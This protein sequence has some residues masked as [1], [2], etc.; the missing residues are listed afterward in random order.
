MPELPEVE[1]VRRTLEPA[2]GR[3]VRGVWTSG[4]PLRLNR[5]V[6][7]A[8]LARAATGAVIAGVRRRGK[9]LLIDLAGRDRLI[10]V[11]LGMSGR[12]R[13]VPA[14]AP[15]AP[16]THVV[17]SLTGGRELRYSDPRRFG[18]VDLAPAGGREREH[19]SLAVLGRDPLVER[20]TG[21]F[22]HEAAR[23]S[24]QTMK[25]ILLDQGIVAGVGN[26]YASE[27][28]WLAGV[29]P[30]LRG[31]RLDRARADALA[32][33]IR[34]VLRRALE[35]GGT[36]LRDFVDADGVAGENAD[37]LRV[38]G[39]AGA[40][41]PRRACS[42]RIRRTVIQGRATFHCPACQRR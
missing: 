17:L 8:G 24:R 34:A 2:V 9:Y 13:I 40:P 27:A 14:R 10:L 5:P 42:G 33:A 1:T 28:L 23:R 7:R 15:R 31:V 21:A 22:L 35:R 36:S 30:T 19:P 16:H 32:R 6:D 4:L 3:R 39:R 26:I 18:L 41:C 25:S 12:L 11:H 38:Y 20:V 29:P 37:Y